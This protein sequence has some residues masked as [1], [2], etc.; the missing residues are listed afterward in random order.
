MRVMI[1]GANGFI[2]REL[3]QR[4]LAGGVLRGQPI[5]ALLL[6]DQELSGLPDDPR[7]RRH[8]GSVTDAALIRR[9]LADGIDV[10]FHLVS[11]PGGAA[12]SRYE[13]GY[14]VNL[15]ASLELL[16]QLRNSNRPPRLVYAS[17]VAVYGADLPSRMDEA[18]LSQPKLSYGSHKLMVETQLTDLARRG[19]V[20]G[21]ALR[22]PGIV[23]R[24]RQANG[25]KSAFMSDLL[26]AVAAGEPYTCP[27][28]PQ[29]TAWWMSARCC[30]DN[31]IH[32]AELPRG[33]ANPVRQLPVLHLSIEQVLDAL[34]GILGEPRR[35]LVSFAPEPELEAL[36]GRYPPLR[37]PQAKALGFRHDGSANALIRNALNLSATRSSRRVVPT[38]AGAPL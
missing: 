35:A 16:N 27:V 37:T 12:E 6:L 9:A 17:S 25:L 36:F 32:A 34:V 5:E 29:A 24:P 28:S 4:L 8:F 10:V 19:D 11:V 13:L 22:L 18:S 15:Q 20:D 7:I 31:L 2:G 26:H 30:V 21:I 3:V 38:L 14:Q 1:T 23:A 33:S